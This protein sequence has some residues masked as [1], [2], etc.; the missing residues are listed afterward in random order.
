MGCHAKCVEAIIGNYVGQK[1]KVMCGVCKMEVN[2]ASAREAKERRER[3]KKALEAKTGVTPLFKSV[4]I[5]ACLDI[6]PS[7][8]PDIQI[9]PP[10]AT[11]A[12]VLRLSQD[13]GDDPEQSS[14][15]EVPITLST[16]FSMF[17]PPGDTSGV[18]SDDVYEEVNENMSIP[19]SAPLP[20]PQLICPAIHN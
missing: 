12:T 15:E 6:D 9:P 1:R 18:P 14:D 13:N 3:E 7:E 19:E 5:Q 8:I 4:T 17:T 16:G 11:A 10:T 20:P 2:E